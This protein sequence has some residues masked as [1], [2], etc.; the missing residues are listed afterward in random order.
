MKITKQTIHYVD[1]DGQLYIRYDA[2]NWSMRIS[3]SEEPV[4]DCEDL[5]K[6]Y[7]KNIDQKIW[8]AH[9]KDVKSVIRVQELE[10]DR[11]KIQSLTATPQEL[12]IVHGVKDFTII[13]EDSLK[14]IGFEKTSRDNETNYSCLT[15]KIKSPDTKCNWTIEYETYNAYK[16]LCI[17]TD[18]RSFSLNHFRF[19]EEVEHLINALEPNAAH[20][21][22]YNN[23]KK[24]P[25]K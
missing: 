16:K 17:K 21:Y 7:Q 25:T 19:I 9:I 22:K 24:I 4:Y 13:D 10:D 2:K 18:N 15:R 3:E 6:E 14:Y 1:L 20:S 23:G 11:K 5:E 12:V 8:E